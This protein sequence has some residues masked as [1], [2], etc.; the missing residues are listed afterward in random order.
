MLSPKLKSFFANSIPFGMTFGFLNM[1]IISGL[2]GIGNN[3]VG[4]I[5]T[6]DT[7]DF[8]MPLSTFTNITS[9]NSISST[10][11]VASSNNISASSIQLADKYSFYIWS[12][13][14]TTGSE[15]NYTNSGFDYINK[16]NISTITT[17]DGTTIEVPYPFIHLKKTLRSLVRFAEAALI[18]AVFNA[19]LVLGV[20]I[21][22][23]CRLKF[24]PLVMY[25]LNAATLMTGIIFAADIT[26]AGIMASSDLHH[27]KQFGADSKLGTTMISIL[28]IAAIHMVA[29]CTMWLLMGLGKMRMN[30]A[31]K[32]NIP[33]EGPESQRSQSDHDYLMSNHR[34]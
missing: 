22:A 21:A 26:A 6:V 4:P 20:G 16:I 13:S 11:E 14:S 29:V 1:V 23:C 25:F 7:K 33:W 2:S 9:F 24:R 3:I 28:W 10:N 27:F 32:L 5:F 34:R 18:A 15:T 19:V 30:S 31:V 8:N 17:T 12:Y